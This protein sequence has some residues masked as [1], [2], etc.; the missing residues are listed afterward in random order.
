MSRRPS[1]SLLETLL[2]AAILALVV[3]ACLPLLTGSPRQTPLRSD[4]DLGRYA[5][6]DAEVSPPNL[7]VE[8]S[9]STVASDIEG[10]WIVV[11][12]ADRIAL[13]WIPIHPMTRESA[14]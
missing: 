10:A 4:P 14:P 7:S 2:A 1:F 9:V 11:R 8:R 3:A 12:S 5:R 6:T 13:T